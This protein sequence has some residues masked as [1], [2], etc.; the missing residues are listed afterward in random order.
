MPRFEKN[1]YKEHP[2]VKARTPEEVEV[3]RKTRQV[4]VRGRSV[5]DPVMSFEEAGFPDYIYDTLLKQGYTEPTAIQAQGW[6]MALTGRDFVGIA[7]TGSGKTIGY[8]LPGIV[9]ISQQARLQRGDG[10]IVL[11]LAPTRELA[12]QVKEVA[13]VF[14]RPSRIRSCCVY[15]GASKGPQIRDL[16]DGVEI[17]I[18]TPGRL[19]D[20]LD[21]GKTNMRRCTYL[22]LDEADRMLDMGFEPQIRK[23]VDLIRPDRQTLMWSATW[24]KEVKSL[25][26]DFLTDY[27]QVNVGSLELCA[28]HN[29]LQIVD[30][31]EEYEKDG[32]LAKLLENIMGEK[33]NKTIIF[34]ETKRRVDEL[35]RQM[36]RDGW[37]AI[38]IHGDKAQ[39]E[40][41]WVLK[42]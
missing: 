1:M 3:Y 30:V 15:G 23:I 19:I 33:D 17:C 2:N 36:R 32:K 37:P 13:D 39:P 12:L 22:V 42:G 26:E 38:C 31:C 10:P 11:V 34:V 28:N 24:P 6:P 29:I 7:Q 9:H 18:A 5:P 14:G 41:E 40:R 8:I 16:Q 27:I 21:A 4:Y 35:T 25:A 20:F